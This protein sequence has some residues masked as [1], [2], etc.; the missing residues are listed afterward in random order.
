[1]NLRDHLQAI[2]DQ[3]GRLTPED[4]VDVARDPEH[5]LHSRFEWDNDAAAEH[6]RRTQAHELIR[7]CRI[8]YA[9]DEVGRER[10]VR[11]FHAVRTEQGHV[12]EPAAK[13]AADPLM[14]R[15]VMADM[16]R[17]WKQLRRK[18]D[19]FAEFW[20]MV[21]GEAEVQTAA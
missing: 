7:T 6:W 19:E 14:A 17:E 4:V 16:E 10:T 9:E 12:Y 1:V 3:R 5:P 20:Q 13:I 2:R 21:R 18:Y 15:I 11:A 8:K